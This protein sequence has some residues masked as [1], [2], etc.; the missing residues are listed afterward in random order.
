MLGNLTAK[1]VDSTTSYYNYN[2]T[3]NRL[4]SVTGGYNFSYDDRGNVSH[5]GK[6]AFTFNRANQLVGSGNVSYVYDGY[7]RRVR[8]QTAAGTNYSLYNSGGQ[9]MLRQNPAAM[10]TFA[11]Y[12][13]KD[14]I[15]E[16]DISATANT[17]RYQHTD[18]LGSVIA[19]SNSA[20]NITSSSVYQPFGERV[21]GQKV[22]V[23]FTGHL[24]DPDLELTYMQQRYYDPVI[25][26]FYSND[27]VG[28]IPTNP[29]MSF[30]RYL[31]VNN[32]PYKYIDPTGMV[33]EVKGSEEFKKKTD[34]AIA[35]ISSKPGG[36]ALVKSLKESKFTVTI[37]ESM[38]GNSASSTLPE[39]TNGKGSDSKIMFN[40]DSTI[41]G[42]DDKGSV[43]R[44]SFVGLAHEMGHSQSYTTGTHQVADKNA[45]G[46]G[47]AGT[48]P[49]SETNSI[50]QEN[51]VR[52][53]HNLTPRS[54]YFPKKS[55]N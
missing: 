30:N 19:E 28:Y 16:R 6:R 40:P 5:N 2:T 3:T 26:R 14:L 41:G 13:G 55:S 54:S 23:G 34:A 11:L 37:V 45:D 9:L 43:Y 49:V 52:N 32:N 51:I 35:K 46:F 36:A 39:A 47:S 15:A 18:V 10:R 33:L 7:N 21:G 27:P 53:E 1:T 38:G 20:G 42:V 25:G 17:V 8:Q 44:P 22:G 48:T 4:S 24:E 50:K 12:L 29:S 31:Y